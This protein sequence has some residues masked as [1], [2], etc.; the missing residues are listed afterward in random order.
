MPPCTGPTLL[1]NPPASPMDLPPSITSVACRQ[2]S[3]SWN[4]SHVHRL[5]FSRQSLCGCVLSILT[6]MPHVKTR[7][8]VIEETD[9]NNLGLISCTARI[10]SAVVV[11]TIVIS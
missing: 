6:G 11:M 3:A 4:V 2:R 10:S 1:R 5:L 9:T 8:T 7:P